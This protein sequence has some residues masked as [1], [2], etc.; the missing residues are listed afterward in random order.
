MATR[1]IGSGGDDA[2][3]A[4]WEAG[5]GTLSEVQIGD[6]LPQEFAE[7]A[8]C[9]GSVTTATNYAHLRAQSGAEH[10]GRAHEVSGAGN[11]RIVN[12]STASLIDSSDDHYR[13]SSFEG[14]GP[15]DNNAATMRIQSVAAG[16]EIH[17]HHLLLHN[18]DANNAT[19]QYGININDADALVYAYRNIIYGQGASGIA[20]SLMAPGSAIYNNT[21]WNTN[22][23]GDA[24]RAGIATS[25]ADPAIEGNACFDNSNLD[26]RNAA[27]TLDWNYTSD[28]TGD[29]EGANGLANLITA[30]QFTAP[31]ATWAST[32]LTHKAGG[33]IAGAGAPTR[34]TATYPEID[35]AADNRGVTI[36]G[37]WDVGACQYVAAGGD[38]YPVAPMPVNYNTTLSRM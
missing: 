22:H 27:G 26:I 1:T 6:L 29:D 7:N 21:V 28:A 25:D 20:S 14:F 32:D 9:S 12:A 34:N 23:S 11:A 31:T 24:F 13:F 38:Q 3:I 33:D 18:N 37:A 8:V 16:G 30:N 5:L 2:N 15:G 4:T 36:S 19:G 35:E 10:D 17:V